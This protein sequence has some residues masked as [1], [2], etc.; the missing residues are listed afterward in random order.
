MRRLN[1][2]LGIF[3][4]FVLTMSV[5]CLN[6]WATESAEAEEGE[7]VVVE[8]DVAQIGEQRFKTFEAAIEA[9]M[10]GD[11]VMLIGNI[12]LSETVVIDKTVTIDL[13]GYSISQV[14]ACTGSYQMIY[15]KGELT[16]KDDSNS[17]KISF[18]DNGAGDP[19]FGWGSY[20]IRNEGTLVINGG[21][22][23][24]LGTQEFA[25]HCI[26]AIFQYSGTTTINGGKIST[27]NYR[28]V[29]LWKGNMNINGGEF[30]GQVWVQAV[31]NSAKLTV[32]GGTFEPNGR[33]G[34]SVFVENSNYDVAF[35][36]VGGT[37]KTK[38]GSS[39][40]TKLAG[41]VKGGSFTESAMNN[42]NTALIDG[43]YY[44][45]EVNDDGY[46]SVIEFNYV[47]WVREQLYAG[48]DVTLDRDIVINGYDLLYFPKLPTNRNGRYHLDHGEGAIFYIV[49]GDVTLDLNGHS[50][51]W[52]AHSEKFCGGVFSTLFRVSITGN[53]K[54]NEVITCSFT[55]EDSV[56]TGAVT[57]YGR[58][59]AMYSTFIYAT[60][61]INGGTWTNYPC[62]ECDETGY[63]IFP[64]HGSLMNITGGCFEQVTVD[65]VTN[66]LLAWQGST[67]EGAQNEWCNYSN[68]RMNISG[69]TFVG[70]DPSKV[71]FINVAGGGAPEI[72]GCADGHIPVDNND[73]TYKVIE[74][75][76]SSIKSM[77]L[78][79]GGNIGMNFGFLFNG[80][81]LAD[82]NAVVAFYDAENNL[83]VDMPISE[84]TLQ[85]GLY[86]YTVGV[87]SL[88]MTKK[89]TVK[90]LD[91]EGN[92][93]D[94]CSSTMSI[95]DYAKVILND[96]ENLYG[97]EYDRTLIKAL[98]TY[99]GYVQKGVNSS[100]SD[101]DLAYMIDGTNYSLSID[102][103]DSVI[104]NDVQI[105]DA[106]LANTCT[107]IQIKSASL[108]LGTETTIQLLFDIANAADYDNYSF[109]EA[110]VV[111]VS[112]TRI[113]VL[114]QDINALELN[115][116]FSIT[117]TNKEDETT[118]T[119]SYSAMNYIKSG[120][121]YE[122][123]LDSA[124]NSYKALYLYSVCT[125][126]WYV[127]Q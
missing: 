95:R 123:H 97:D 77:H 17:G 7:D 120:I 124:K 99:G 112:D 108:I 66:K 32:A 47:L 14:K 3:L 93:V 127:E 88:E 44:D 103:L 38:I 56:G 5:I 11:T 91:G 15:N 2:W 92:A 45:F 49:N 69:G 41:S 4:T 121:G 29:R 13:N 105:K 82:E 46:Y 33:D 111:K 81:L 85:N 68:T 27:P 94:K 24:H 57:V 116:V 30:D 26:M 101:E 106:V 73:G 37:F 107:G 58:P 21:T 84:G 20:T 6:V 115:D 53:K 114:I 79:L 80:K 50:I 96:N 71:K 119:Y 78:V 72:N 54:N 59:A 19:N 36:V 60:A 28:S 25:T 9:A 113:K 18:T 83:I 125:E 118:A 70:F 23:E 31:D 1:H 43:C 52:N 48:N 39:D 16:I 65:G 109:G 87:N 35:E 90:V 12:V 102:D 74:D 63:F 8:A 61:N 51:T 76:T 62:K 42:T 55:V 40:A 86:R 126:A 75:I 10:Q 67:T 22:I 117:V 98:L 100:V 64:S 34:S 122:G 110:T 89:I 104:N